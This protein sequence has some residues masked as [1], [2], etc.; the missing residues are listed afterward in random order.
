MAELSSKIVV[1]KLFLFSSTLGFS[2][3]SVFAFWPV[4]LVK[5]I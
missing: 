3:L 5:K 2:F 1:T 4:L